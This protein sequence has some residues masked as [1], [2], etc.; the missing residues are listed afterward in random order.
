MVS[1]R[2][3]VRR[4]NDVQVTKLDELLSCIS[5]LEGR[6]AVHRF[7]DLGMKVL[8]PIVIAGATMIVKHEI[9]IQTAEQVRFTKSEASLLESRLNASAPPGWL[10]EQITEIN[11]RLRTIEQKVR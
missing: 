9:Q 3:E 5:K 8:I 4:L 6:K 10:R 1:P 11:G 2:P 7:W